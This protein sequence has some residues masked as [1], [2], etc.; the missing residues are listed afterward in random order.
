MKSKADIVVG[1]VHVVVVKVDVDVEWRSGFADDRVR[2]RRVSDAVE[3]SS[4]IPV[5]LSVR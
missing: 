2:H 4:A 1:H 3:I 5:G